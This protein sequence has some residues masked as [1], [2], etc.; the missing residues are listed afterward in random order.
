MQLTQ[1]VHV[2]EQYETK[3]TKVSVEVKRLND[4]LGDKIEDIKALE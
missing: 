4:V 3:L 1:Q 2:V